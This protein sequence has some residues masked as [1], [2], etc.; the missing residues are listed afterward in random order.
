MSGTGKKTGTLRLLGASWRLMVKRCPKEAL[1]I[2]CFTVAGG[3][4]AGA[5]TYG[6]KLFFGAIYYLTRGNGTATGVVYSFALLL[7]L[8]VTQSAFKVLSGLYQPKFMEEVKLSILG[9]IHE[10]VDAIPTEFYEDSSLY[11]KMHRANAIVSSGRFMKFF[12][13]GIATAQEII[14]VISVSLVLASFSLSLIP[15]C[16]LSVLPSFVARIVRGTRYYYMTVYQTPRIRLRDYLWS[17]L[18]SKDSL[19]EARVFGFGDYLKDRWADCKRELQDEEWA[20]TRKHALIQLAVDCSKSAGL[21]AGLLLLVWLMT[22]DA[23]EVGAFGAAFASLQVVQSSFN[24]FLVQLSLASEKVPFVA[25]LF[26][27]LGTEETGSTGSLVFSQLRSGIE[28]DGV[29]FAYPGTDKT[30]L[31]DIN[32]K[33]RQGETVALVGLNGAGKTTLAKLIL[34]LYKPTKGR[35]KYDG[36][37]LTEYDMKAVYKRASAVFQDYMRYQLTLRENIG[38]GSIDEIDDDSRIMEAIEQVE[39]EDVLKKLPSGLQSQLGREFGGAELSGGEWQKVAIARGI[40][41]RGDIVVLDEP[42]AS[43]DPVTESEVFRK[44]AGLAKGRTAILISHRVSSARLADRIVVLEEG[45]IVETGSHEELM[46]RR[47][48]YHEL[49]SLQAQWYR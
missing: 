11:D 25:D 21:G 24:S 26:R 44:F 36:I 7:I 33:I 45:R 49:F 20:F 23:L 22:K 10:K 17:L 46:E 43:L 18:I 15:P 14:T 8:Y 4:L 16:F 48:R 1:S 39:L 34:G 42:T 13:N 9:E 31:K 5:V 6:W 28:V 37:D 32:L 12:L 2:A 3:A 27:F 29:S 30:V 40:I 47:G 38:F 35:I 41:R 19:K